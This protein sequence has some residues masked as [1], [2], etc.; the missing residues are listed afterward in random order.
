MV[1]F[2]GHRLAAG[3]VLPVGFLGHSRLARALPSLSSMV[4]EWAKAWLF[5]SSMLWS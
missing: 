1:A 4:T 5:A 2:A 3:I